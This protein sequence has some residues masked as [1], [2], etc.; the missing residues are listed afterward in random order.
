MRLFKTL[1]A[2]ALVV[3]AGM[4]APL[5]MAQT[6]TMKLS[7][8]TN[9]DVLFEWLNT[10]KRGIEASSGGK[11]KAEVYPSSQ[12]GS[13]P[14][15]I[16]GVALGTIE[17]SMNASGFFEGIEPRFS[18]MA[19]PGLFKSAAHTTQVLTD[20]ESQKRLASF[21]EGKGVAVLTV[22]PAA[23]YAI[24]SHKPIA[25]LADFSGQKIRVPGSPI[26]L[27]Q[28]KE[29]GAL[30]LSMPFGEVLPALQNKT[31]DGVWA[32]PNLFVA[33]KYYDVAKTYTTLPDSWAVAVALINRN[34]LK[35]IG[36]DL[37]R[38][39]FEEAR[40][41]DAAMV[42]WGVDDMAKAV[43]VWKK[44][45]GTALEL[46]PADAKVFNEKSLAVAKPL[47]T[48]TPTQQADLDAF[49]KVAEKYSK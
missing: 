35:T 3:G 26:Q 12:L 31:I 38:M 29:F 22:I 19:A 33:F 45:G 9:N 1:C 17:V 47:L 34:F 41:A 16:E 8:S 28:M 30:P 13:I 48:T 46:S 37:E 14:R 11:I 7:T 5:A 2:A 36:P 6:Y 18:V 44:N 20:P 25:A 32:A 15:T 27:A 21:G 4:A 10:F 42:K 24:I 23:P 40:K 39:V 43:D 49:L